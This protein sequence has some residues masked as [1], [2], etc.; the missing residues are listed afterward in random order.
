MRSLSAKT[1][2]VSTAVLER[3][4][5]VKGVL[6]DPHLKNGGAA[7]GQPA[8]KINEEASPPRATFWSSCA[9]SVQVNFNGGLR[10]LRIVAYATILYVFQNSG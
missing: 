7:G 4:A 5:P 8:A 3:L 9:H 10:T 2:G 6:I 1:H